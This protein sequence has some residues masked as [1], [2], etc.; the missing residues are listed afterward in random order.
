MKEGDMVCWKGGRSRKEVVIGWM[1]S[2]EKKE[3]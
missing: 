3:R 2:K 1:S